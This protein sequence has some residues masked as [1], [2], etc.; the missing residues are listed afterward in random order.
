MLMRSSPIL[1]RFLIWIVLPVLILLVGTYSYLLQSLPQ[2]EGTI[3]LKG[4]NSAVKVTRDE[5][6]IAHI[7]AKTDHDVFF[8]LGYIHAQ[9]RIWQMSFMKRTGQ[10]RLSEILGRPSIETDKLMRTLGYYKAAESAVES[11]D[12][13]TRNSLQAYAD[14]VNTWIGEKHT[15]PPEFAILGTQPEKWTPADSLV[16]K[17]LISFTLGRLNLMAEANYDMLVKE[18]GVSRADDLM[19]NVNPDKKFN[20]LGQI[21]MDTKR[22]NAT[23]KQALM[24]IL[25]GQATFPFDGPAEGIGSNAWVVSGEHTNSGL[26]LMAGDPHMPVEIP[27]GWYLVD[28]KGDRLNVTGAT[29]PGVPVVFMGRNQS[30]SWSI[31]NMLADAM[32]L[33]VQRTNPLNANQYEFEGEWVDMEVEDQLIHIK[34]DSPEILTMPI[35]PMKWQV[36]RTRHGPV[37]SDAEAIFDNP[38]SLRWPGFDKVDR[39]FKSF[40]DINYAQDWTSFKT[41]LEDLKIPATNFVYGDVHGDIGLFGAGKLPIRP[42][43][44]GRMPVPGW[45]AKYEWDGY[46]PFELA[47][48]VLNPK[49]GYVSNSNNKNHEDDYP[50][51]ISNIWSA[52]YRIDRVNQ[53]LEAQ[54]QSGKKFTNEDFIKLQGDFESL[55]VDEVLAFL[56]KLPTKTPEQKEAIEKLKQWDR[57]V[58]VDS[59]ANVIYQSWLRHFNNGLW[60]DDIRGTELFVTRSDRL[61]ALLI[62]IKPRFIVKVLNKDPSIKN[63]W[64][65]V[66]TTPHQESCEQLALS[67]LDSALD[68]IDRIVGSSTPWGEV[69]N[70]YYPHQVFTNMEILD[71]IFD[72]K[73]EYGGDRYT[74][75]SGQWVYIE[76]RGY[77]VISS[78]NY[79]HVIDLADKHKSVFIQNTGQ[80]GNIMSEH[81]DDY[82][83]PFSELDMYPMYLSDKQSTANLEVL[84]LEPAQ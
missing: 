12:D 2:T 52:P 72:R 81:Y 82:I 79:R 6:A 68:E 10:G 84:H 21:A 16:I 5:Y 41:A 71:S 70:I 56:L 18:L 67:A 55:L 61:Q 11:L 34:Q 47:P 78:A 48:R 51:I 65:D 35:P 27:S 40:L 38:I 13:A 22:D 15:L 58:A 26:P 73:L 69:H 75:N 36:R 20:Q 50:H 14:G 33:Y 8:A 25:A 1:S 29:Y 57:V 83:R 9:E 46:I 42:N 39:S 74:V 54:I 30:I 32:D 3:K 44:N 17:K 7:E 53:V 64:C 76:G 66:V 23:D 37:I 43:S 49:E 28:M 60:G 4:L 31:T 62:N 80:S 77:Q 45:L 59:V 24:G 63:D 19:P